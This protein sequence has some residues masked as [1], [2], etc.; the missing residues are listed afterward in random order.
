MLNYYYALRFKG[1]IEDAKAYFSTKPEE[2][3]SKK[4]RVSELAYGTKFTKFAKEFLSD[5]NQKPTTLNNNV[6][7]IAYVRHSTIHRNSIDIDKYENDILEKFKEIVEKQGKTKEDWE[8]F[9]L[10][11]K[12]QFKQNS[13]FSLVKRVTNEFSQRFLWHI[14]FFATAHSQSKKAKEPQSQRTKTDRK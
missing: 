8:I 7:L 6:Q 10:G 12:V 4:F 1:K 3:S 9:N 5:E 13:S 14:C 2:D 11:R